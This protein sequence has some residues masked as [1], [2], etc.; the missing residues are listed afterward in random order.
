MVVT[1]TPQPPIA[2]PNEQSGYSCCQVAPVLVAG[3]SDLTYFTQIYKTQNTTQC[4]RMSTLSITQFNSQL[5]IRIS[6][7]FLITSI[8]TRGYR[9]DTKIRK[10]VEDINK[11]FA[12][13]TIKFYVVIYPTPELT[14]RP[15]WCGY[16]RRA[17]AETP[18]DVAR[19]D[20]TQLQLSYFYLY[21]LCGLTIATHEELILST[22]RLFINLDFVVYRSQSFTAIRH[23]NNKKY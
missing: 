13:L 12:N 22:D 21:H 14:K 20:A 23:F 4:P 17:I 2:D 9:K 15:H 3:L 6:Y 5:I 11:Q 10:F 7:L 16:F 18:I 1:R 19:Q 8:C